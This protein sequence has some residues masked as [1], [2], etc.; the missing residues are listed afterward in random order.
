MQKKIAGRWPNARPILSRY[1]AP[2]DS[3]EVAART[4]RLL[5]KQGAIVKMIRVDDAGKSPASYGLI[6]RPA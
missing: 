4:G 5:C 6:T 2:F 1:A 3:L